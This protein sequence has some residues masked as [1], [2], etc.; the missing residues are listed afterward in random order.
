MS[1][2]APV[3]TNLL[4]QVNDLLPNAQAHTP[5]GMTEVLPVT[6]I[7]LAQ[8]DEA[9][10]GD[11]VCVGPALPGV[12]IAVSELDSLGRA[13]GPPIEKAG[14][15][16]EICVRA[17]HGK[18]RYDALW[19]TERASACHSGW[20]RT[21]DVGYLDTEGRL[22]VQGRLQHLITTAAGLVTPVGL[23]LGLEVLPSVRAAAV[24]GVGPAG[25]QQVV[26]V[27]VPAKQRRRWSSPVADLELVDAVRA[28]S[29]VPIAAVLTRR[30]LPVDVRH[31]SKVDRTALA[32]W[33]S[34][35]LAGRV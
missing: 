31:A 18:E 21:G 17:A 9:G 16:G 27:L 34:K 29:P 22:W 32:G 2:G 15:T 5:Y 24:V 20:H 13:L 25:T 11:G 10:A 35:A 26:A 8:I 28:A 1:A 19:A 12:A 30:S 6:D 4:E 23:E 14:V 3:P 7:S 33:A